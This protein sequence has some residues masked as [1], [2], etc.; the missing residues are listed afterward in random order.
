MT[1]PKMI[2]FDYGHTLAYEPSFDGIKGEEAVLKYATRNKNNLSAKEVSDFSSK[3]FDKVLNKTRVNGI[4]IH[5][6][7]FQ[8]LIYEFLEIEIPLSQNE[9]EKIFMDN[10]EP[11]FLMPD[12]DKIIDYINKNGIRSGVISNIMNSG[13][14]L[15]DRVNSLLPDNRFEFIIASSEYIFRKPDPIIFELALKKAK[16]KPEEVWFCGDNIQVD[17]KGASAVGIFPVWYENKLDCYYREKSN[18]IPECEHLH[19]KEWP[20][21]IDILNKLKI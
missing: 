7:H 4:E 21:L 14:A 16:L 17:I 8:R 13:K 10:A 1:F 5:S 3:L 9:I 11:V 12:A 20:E 18:D 15:E 2:M 6:H 19:I